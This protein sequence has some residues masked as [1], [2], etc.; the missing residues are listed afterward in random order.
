[1]RKLIA[2]AVVLLIPACGGTTGEVPPA[3]TTAKPW[4]DPA[5]WGGV[6]PAAGSAVLI[7][8]GERII[9]DENTPALGGLTILGTLE[10][11][12][13]DLTLTARWI[14]VHGRLE[15]GTEA[16]PFAQ[17]AVITLT[18]DNPAENVMGMGTRGLMVMGGVLDL[19]GVAPP[20]AWTRLADHAPAGATT[21]TVAGSAPGWR[22]GD[23][24]VIAPTDFYEGASETERVTVQAV[25]GTQI[26][27]ATPLAAPRWGRL[28]HVTSAGMSL[29][30]D[31]SVTPP[32]PSTPMVLDERAEVGNL[33]RNLVIQAPDDALWRNDG[34]GAHVMIMDLASSVRVDAVEFRRTGQR[35]V[36]GRYPIHWHRLSYPDGVNVAGDATGHYVRNS[37]FNRST[38]R[39]VTVHATNGLL[40]RNNIGYDIVGQ[41]MFTEDAVERRNVF[42]NNLILRVR[43]P[44]A[45]QAL[46][47][48]DLN[49]SPN[50]G[51]SGFWISNPD[52]TLR[53]NVVADAEGFGVWMAFPRRPVG[54]SAGV[55][56][57]PDRLRFGVFEDNTVH[58]NGREGVMIDFAEIDDLGNVAANRYI[59]TSDGQDPVWPYPNQERFTL[60]RLTSTKNRFGGLWDRVMWP[61]ILECVVADNNGRYIAGAGDEGNVE[62][63]LLVGTSLNATPR[64]ANAEP[65]TAFAT[66][67]STFD[68]KR[69]IAVNFPL[70]AGERSGVFS[71]E[72]YYIRP[73][74]K[75]HARNPGNQ[76]INSHPGYRVPLQPARSFALAGALWDP[77]GVWGPAG[78]W[79]VYNEPFFTY[80]TT[81]Q[82]IVPD[83][84]LLSNPEAGGVSCNGGPFYGVLSFMKNGAGEM[85][86]P[87]FAAEF[88][89]EATRYDPAMSPIGTW[90]VEAGIPGVG[91]ENMRHVAVAS[92]GL[93]R[94]EFP[95]STPLVNVGFDL[96]NLLGTDDTFVIGVRLSGPGGQ[97]YSSTNYNYLDDTL[98]PSQKRIYAPQASL[99]DV[100]ASVGETFWQDP[101]TNVV[102]IKVRGGVPQPWN[103]ADYPPFSEQRLYRMFHLRI[104]R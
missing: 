13:R 19:H 34:F 91:L 17:S 65:P 33:T 86:N 78:N 81:C 41:A 4:S 72:D 46:K 63:C 30:P 29:T 61:D 80:G 60:R 57:Q 11:D 100:L 32:S 45:G 69:N 62:N 73:V 89:V 75:G 38:N 14:M 51:S 77:F 7:P 70:I 54:L 37:T 103:D 50:G 22:A 95:G 42:E 5:T 16:A 82:P 12:R 21:I 36:L 48:H 40:I 55:V 58:G 25:N 52:N 83:A 44:P 93:Y 18:G 15:V 43:N 84:G 49:N 90:R 92:G 101:A 56:L 53:G 24:I 8:A 39:C 10:F 104:Y 1:M 67:H 20:V 3:S 94:L 71:T 27:L 6:K 47:R 98:P 79:S 87:R 85:P 35:A 76:W 102:W 64:P 23:E 74:D 97:V 59:S 28:Q 68:L 31:A 88:A 9:L 26:T 2:L 96:E 99:A 66:Y